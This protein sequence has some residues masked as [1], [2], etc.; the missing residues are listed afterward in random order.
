MSIRRAISLI[1]KLQHISCPIDKF[2]NGKLKYGKVT[3]SSGTVCVPDSCASIAFLRAVLSDPGLTSVTSDPG[4]TS[5][6][7]NP[8]VTSDLEVTS[9]TSDL[10]SL[11]AAARSISSSSELSGGFSEIK[12][13][14]YFIIIFIINTLLTLIP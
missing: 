5:V 6:T 1:L 14:Y 3:H 10:G 11:G 9:V 2:Q 13:F 7:S 8:G 12:M 4:V